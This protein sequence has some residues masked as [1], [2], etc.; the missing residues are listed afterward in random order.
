MNPKHFL[1]KKGAWFEPLTFRLWGNRAEP[2]A[3]S[4]ARKC[5]RRSLTFTISWMDQTIS[6][7]LFQKCSLTTEVVPNFASIVDFVQVRMDIT[8]ET[9]SEVKSRL[10]HVGFIGAKKKS[11]KIGIKGDSFTIC[12]VYR[13]MHFM[14]TFRGKASERGMSR[15]LRLH[16][17][18]CQSKNIGIELNLIFYTPIIF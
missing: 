13:V 7:P 12:Q 5:L 6:K 15:S 17:T 14:P 4:T 16:L 8:A 2:N 18:E 9:Q 10:A 3:T 11:E 1:M